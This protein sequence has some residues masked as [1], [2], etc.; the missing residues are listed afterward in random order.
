MGKVCFIITPIGKEESDVRKNAD[1]VL[2]YIIN[3]VCN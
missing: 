3:S 2:D 1:E